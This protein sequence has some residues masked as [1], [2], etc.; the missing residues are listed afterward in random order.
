[1]EEQLGFWLDGRLQEVVTQ[2][3]STVSLS[4]EF[5]KFTSQQE[6]TFQI[7]IASL[8]QFPS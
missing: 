7:L 4:W 3:G 5:N 1:M 2:G 8:L 6:I